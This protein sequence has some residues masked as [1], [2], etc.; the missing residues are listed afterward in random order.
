M[1]HF[2]Y[3][4]ADFLPSGSPPSGTG[5]PHAAA[6]SLK[7]AQLN[8]KSQ[9]L[10]VWEWS[11]E[12]VNEMEAKY[13]RTDENWR[14]SPQFGEEEAEPRQTQKASSVLQETNGKC[15]RGKASC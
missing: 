6:E 10:P 1:M 5:H 11:T 14:A 12:W 7:D 9:P 4:F 3:S 15:F 2:L 8:P 13:S